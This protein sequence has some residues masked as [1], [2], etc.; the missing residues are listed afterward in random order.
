MRCDLQGL[1]TKRPT[2]ADGGPG[3]L[4]SLMSTKLGQ[5]VLIEAWESTQYA[6]QNTR[7]LSSSSVQ[8]LG[9]AI[10]GA[11]SAAALGSS[12]RCRPII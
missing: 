10:V 1:S 4:T 5:P 6:P 3:G 12:N 11:S 8:S 2:D 9:G 7:L